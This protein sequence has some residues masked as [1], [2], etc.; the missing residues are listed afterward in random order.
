MTLS[1]YSRCHTRVIAS[2]SKLA[3]S[4]IHAGVVWE[5]KPHSISYE[6][7]SLWACAKSVLGE[8]NKPRRNKSSATAAA[9]T[10]ARKEDA[11]FTANGAILVQPY[12]TLISNNCATRIWRLITNRLQQDNFWLRLSALKTHHFWK[13]V[14]YYS[15]IYVSFA[16]L[17][18]EYYTKNSTWF[19]KAGKHTNESVWWK[20][21]LRIFKN[22]TI[23]H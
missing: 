6:S 23:L 3:W 15:K 11:T 5:Q 16:G 2:A 12:K 10:K 17:Q 20:F 18:L 7:H 21:P 9:W 14:S 22:S 13:S 4:I 19:L 1:K 8:I